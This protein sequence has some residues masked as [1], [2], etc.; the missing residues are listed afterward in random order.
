MKEI[1]FLQKNKHQWELVEK[2]VKGDLDLSPEELKTAYLNL[3]DSLSYSRTFYPESKTTIYLNNLALRVHSSI[4]SK[5]KFDIDS[6]KKF[7]IKDLPLLMYDSR[8]E[9][10]ISFL[11]FF[12]SMLIGIISTKYDDSFIRLILGND[13]VAMT[14]RNIEKGDPMGVYKTANQLD[15]FIGITLNNIMVSFNCFVF[16]TFTSLGTGFILFRNGVMLGS[17]Q[18]FFVEQGLFYEY[19]RTVWIHGTL[20]IS[21]IVIAGA[22]GIKFGNSVLFPGTYTRLV[23]FQMGAIQ[24]VKILLSLI[25]MFFIAG[26]LEGFVT[27]LTELPDVF[28][29]FVILLSLTFVIWYFVIFPSIIH[30]RSLYA[31]FKSN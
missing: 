5:K 18:Q 29:F 12:V 1:I 15:M 2:F 28:N 13:Y 11:V 6:F 24:G 9:L 23:S 8:K 31:E 16:G 19:F 22:A 30:R 21:A 10:L 25:P 27:R 4:Y 20:E 3:I 7:W 26:F 14:L 17:F